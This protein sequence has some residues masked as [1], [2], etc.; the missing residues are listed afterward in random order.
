MISA[1]ATIQGLRRPM[2]SRDRAGE[3][4]QHGDADADDRVRETPEFL[5]V[6]RIADDGVREIRREDVDVDE[7]QVR[8]ARELEQRPG[9]LPASV[10]NGLTRCGPIGNAGSHRSQ[11]G[12]C[13][14]TATP[15]VRTALEIELRTQ[16]VLTRRRC[17]I[18]RRIVLDAGD[19]VLVAALVT[20]SSGCPAVGVWVRAS[21]DRSPACAP[22]A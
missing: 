5:A 21:A 6:H 10:R 13:G 12:G 14:Q 8:R 19:V 16:T 22:V 11:G 18:Q 15:G 3:R 4:R 1:I 7:A 20:Q 9:K 2:R 17:V